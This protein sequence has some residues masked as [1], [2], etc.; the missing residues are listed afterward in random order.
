MMPAAAGRYILLERPIDVEVV[1]VTIQ[2]SG[3]DQELAD[4]SQVHLYVLAVI[5]PHVDHR[6]EILLPY[7]DLIVQVVAVAHLN[8]GGAFEPPAIVSSA[9]LQVRYLDFS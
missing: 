5:V 8:T 6:N 4:S 1:A 9:P 2:V 3:R 7:L